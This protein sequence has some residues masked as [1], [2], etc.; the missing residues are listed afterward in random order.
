MQKQATVNLLPVQFDAE[1][2]DFQKIE[3]VFTQEN[4]ANAPTLKSALWVNGDENETATREEGTNIID[5]PWSNE[6]TFLFKRASKF[7]MDTR[8]TPKNVAENPITPIVELFMCPSLFKQGE[9]I[10][11]DVDDGS[12]GTE[13]DGTGG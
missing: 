7:F 2:D 1:L 12:D 11:G 8:I 9:I 13:G 5:I 10:T 6:D 3:F 4:K